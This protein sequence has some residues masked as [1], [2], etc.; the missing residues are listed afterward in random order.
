MAPNRSAAERRSDSAPTGSYQALLDEQVSNISSHKSLEDE[1]YK[2]VH[3][4]DETKNQ[5]V[6]K[7]LESTFVFLRE[8][9]INKNSVNMNGK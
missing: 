5:Y 1:G 4:E 7:L 2:L 8:K 6:I 3:I 9:H